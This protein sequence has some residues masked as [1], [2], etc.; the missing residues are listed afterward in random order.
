MNLHFLLLKKNL[1]GWDVFSDK[2][3][4][5]SPHFSKYLLCV[6]NSTYLWTCRIQTSEICTFSVTFLHWQPFSIIISE[7]V[8]IIN[9]G[10]HFKLL[11]PTQGKK[12]F[13]AVNFTELCLIKF[14][15]T[16]LRL[17]SFLYIY[18][19]CRW[20]LIFQWLHSFSHSIGC[21]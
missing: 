10:Y 5:H 2:F 3:W 9:A 8:V 19:L 18:D 4:I 16:T 7:S 15:K 6:W 12:S 14:Y 11:C 20:L 1:Q 21:N 13:A 17:G